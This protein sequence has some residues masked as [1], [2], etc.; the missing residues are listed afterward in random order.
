MN[1]TKRYLSGHKPVVTETVSSFDG[2][3]HIYD[4]IEKSSATPSALQ[5]RLV[6]EGLSEAIAGAKSMATGSTT[7]NIHVLGDGKSGKSVI[8]RMMAEVL[9]HGTA[10]LDSMMKRLLQ[11]DPDP[12]S[13]GRG[14]DRK[15]ITVTEGGRSVT[16]VIHDYES[17][18]GLSVSHA[19]S[20]SIANSIYCII[21]PLVLFEDDADRNRLRSE[22][23][24]MERYSYW[25]K[26]LYSVVKKSDSKHLIPVNS[27]SLSASS[28]DVKVDGIASGIPL[29]TILNR[30]QLVHVPP[31][32]I[33]RIQA[34]LADFLKR[35]FDVFELPQAPA[36]GGSPGFERKSRTSLNLGAR[37][38]DFILPSKFAA[39]LDL[40]SRTDVLEVVQELRKCIKVAFAAPK[41]SF[42]P[43]LNYVL[44]K[45]PTLS[46]PMFVTQ[47]TF[48]EAIR[49][50]LDR[51]DFQI[52]YNSLNSSTIQILNDCVVEYVMQSLV[53]MKKILQFSS[54]I[55]SHKYDLI[56]EP[57]MLATAMYSDLLYWYSRHGPLQKLLHEQP[58]ALKLQGRNLLD[59]L[60][61]V[62]KV[63]KHAAFSMKEQ[64]PPLTSIDL[65]SSLNEALDDFHA[66]S[67]LNYYDLT[68]PYNDP[69]M[70]DDRSNSSWLLSINPA[71]PVSTIEKA[72]IFDGQ[73]DCE[74]RRYF[75]LVD[76]KAM[77]IPGFFTKLV[78]W[79]IRLNP[80][81]SV[82]EGYSNGVKIAGQEVDEE[83]GCRFVKQILLYEYQED[84]KGDDNGADGFIVA[85]ATT[86]GP[87]SRHIAFDD[88]NN[89]RSLLYNQLDDGHMWGLDF[90]EFCLDSKL[91]NH[92]RLHSLASVESHVFG[93]STSIGGDP[94]ARLDER[95]KAK[96]LYFG[97]MDPKV[98]HTNS[99]NTVEALSVI[100][101]HTNDYNQRQL[102]SSIDTG[103]A[104]LVENSIHSLEDLKRQVKNFA[105]ANDDDSANSEK[106]WKLYQV[107]KLFCSLPKFR[108]FYPSTDSDM[109]HTP[110]K[111]TLQMFEGLFNSL[112]ASSSSHNIL[113]KLTSTVD[114]HDNL[115]QPPAA[116]DVFAAPILMAV[117]TIDFMD[118]AYLHSPSYTSDMMAIYRSTTNSPLSRQQSNGHHRTGKLHTVHFLCQICGKIPKGAE[119]GY[120]I[121]KSYSWFQRALHATYNSMRALEFAL[122]VANMQCGV[123]ASGVGSLNV[124]GGSECA[125]K[126]VNDSFVAFNTSM[127]HDIPTEDLTNMRTRLDHASKGLPRNTMT[128]NEL[129]PLTQEQ[130][131]L[132]VFSV[133]V[134]QVQQLQ[135]VA[136]HLLQTYPDVACGLVKVTRNHP[137]DTA[138]V[139][140]EGECLDCFQ[141]T[142]RALI[143]FRI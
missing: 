131:E 84:S 21:V 71:L 41:T 77:L 46:L 6:L 122:R 95:L 3:L 68:I 115:P 5:W 19:N 23:E 1:E 16:Y 48:R 25:T 72:L 10:L 119:E 67:L 75:R 137:D 74:V 24:I 70:R 22:E 9:E 88:L 63:R 65:L 97:Y 104:L 56:T 94:K 39:L 117:K 47:D 80:F 101:L 90:E 28:Y 7:V 36:P 124:F 14:V 86:G 76:S 105:S 53:S 109:T 106:R 59:R 30:F 116:V 127:T 29:I 40:T 50:L 96:E 55:S 134:S 42:S 85:F 64:H 112:S 2:V 102:N 32:H 82:I 38:A 78:S 4:L 132:S 49:T 140:C 73:P 54:P 12:R 69:K 20:L 91:S 121:Y 8:V 128:I 37:N 61:E 33:T 15:S 123:S 98:F 92:Q 58:Q 107:M 60:R 103:L 52:D 27:I 111:I 129:T 110:P 34:S 87:L 13:H 141:K 57:V 31:E 108:Y 45:L 114:S 44:E 51:F 81:C 120:R 135:S 26:Y 139:C 133:E 11:S 89:F 100:P 125:L 136:R 130:V 126:L 17:Q 18:D 83:N 35:N 142:G 43:I 62:D 143:R 93:I 118:Q 138:W 66:A 99:V 113:T 79:I